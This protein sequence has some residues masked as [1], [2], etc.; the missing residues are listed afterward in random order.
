MSSEGFNLEESLLQ[1]IYQSAKKKEHEGGFTAFDGL[2]IMAGCALLA[3]MSGCAGIGAKFETY[4]ID[5]MQ[6]SQ[7]THQKPIPLICYIKSCNEQT[8]V[9]GS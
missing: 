6:A 1:T 7:V 3:F 4:R 5:E 9:S 2:I 8:E